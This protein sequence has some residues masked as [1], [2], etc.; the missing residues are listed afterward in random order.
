M[1]EK[2]II[3]QK[4]EG[5]TDQNGKIE[6]PTRFFRGK[7]KTRKLLR[8]QIGEDEDPGQ[9]GKEHDQKIPVHRREKRKK[10]LQQKTVCGIHVHQVL[11][12]RAKRADGEQIDKR[13]VVALIPDPENGAQRSADK[14]KGE[15]TDDLR[16]V[17]AKC[18]LQEALSRRTRIPQ[19]GGVLALLLRRPHSFPPRQLNLNSFCVTL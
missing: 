17:F 5:N 12:L 13:V 2:Q 10:P 8:G 11:A 7:E 15:E 4:T 19:R 14:Q 9:I 1:R 18:P 16:P 3:L 6:K